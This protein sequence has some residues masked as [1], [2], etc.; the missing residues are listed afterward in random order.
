MSYNLLNP[1]TRPQC[2]CVNHAEG[3]RIWFRS[4]V[5]DTLSFTWKEVKLAL[6]KFSNCL[7]EIRKVVQK[8]EMNVRDLNS[9]KT[10]TDM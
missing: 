9:N 1:P 10:P 4:L 5:P 2:V 7:K 3:F 6:V 8:I